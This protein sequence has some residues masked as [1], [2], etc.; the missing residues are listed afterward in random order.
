MLN[1]SFKATN[2]YL[3]VCGIGYFINHSID[4]T[5]K[6]HVIRERAPPSNCFGSGKL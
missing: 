3:Q 1:I 5:R 2:A 6:I 4:L